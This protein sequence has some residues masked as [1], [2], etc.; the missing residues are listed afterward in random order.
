MKLRSIMKYENALLTTWKRVVQTIR[1]KWKKPNY[2]TFLNWSRLHEALPKHSIVTGCCAILIIIGRIRWTSIGNKYQSSRPIASSISIK[3]FWIRWLS[4]QVIANM[5]NARPAS[6]IVNCNTIAL[7]SFCHWNVFAIVLH[8]FCD[9]ITLWINYQLKHHHSTAQ[10]DEAP[11]KNRHKHG[12]KE[13][14]E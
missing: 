9:T 4:S 5:P 11:W 12:L 13:D 7:F 3:A 6:K 14:R 2:L 1:Y 10:C 8:L